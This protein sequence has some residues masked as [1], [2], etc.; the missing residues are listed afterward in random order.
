MCGRVGLFCLFGLDPNT[1]TK[2]KQVNTLNQLESKKKHALVERIVCAL[3]AYLGFFHQA[4]YPT[5]TY[6]KHHTLLPPSTLNT[7][8]HHQHFPP[9]Q[10]HTEL[11]ALEPGM[12]ELQHQLRLSRRAFAQQARVCEARRMQLEL[13][14]STKLTVS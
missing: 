1:T 14:L 2:T 3:Y 11:A 4:R 9:Q 5:F 13:L 6:N 10:G 7:I 12:R 8:T